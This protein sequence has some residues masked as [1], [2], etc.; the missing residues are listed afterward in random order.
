[1]SEQGKK[2]KKTKFE[3]SLKRL[4]QI[5]S[6]LEDGDLEL[7]KSIELFEEGIG[8]AKS[9]QKKLD[10][11][12]RKIETLVRDKE[13]VLSTQPSEETEDTPA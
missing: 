5:V 2:G 3:E 8:I 10:D 6:K 9:C 11:A 13:G 4:E 12:D 1:M 7:E